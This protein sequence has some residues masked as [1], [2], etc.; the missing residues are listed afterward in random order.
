MQKIAHA[1]LVCFVVLGL[2]S[3]SNGDYQADPASNGNGAVNPVTPLASSEFT[4]SGTEPM[5]CD[6]N[7]KR[8]VADSVSFYLDD[9][10]ANLLYGFQFGKTPRFGF[11]LKDVWS[12]NDYPMEWKN[13][14]RYAVYTDSLGYIDGTFYSYLSNSGGLKIVQNDSAVIKGLFYFKGISPNGK[15]VNISNGYFKIDK[16]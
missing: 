13:Y 7:G 1:L 6:I 5:S 16:L 2:A 4:W 3:C 14:N 11:Y 15:I 8:W 10:G 9:S 12:G